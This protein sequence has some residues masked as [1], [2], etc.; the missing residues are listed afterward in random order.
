VEL[1]VDLVVVQ[2]QLPQPQLE[3]H[4]LGTPVAASQ[5]RSGGLAFVPVPVPRRGLSGGGGRRARGRF[6]LRR[7]RARRR[8]GGRRFRGGRRGRGARAVGRGGGGR[9]ARRRCRGRTGRRCRGGRWG[10][11]GVRHARPDVVRERPVAGRRLVGEQAAGP[12]GRADHQHHGAGGR[13]QCRAAP[14]AR[15]GGRGGGAVRRVR[16]GAAGRPVGRVR[17]LEQVQVGGARLGRGRGERS[18]E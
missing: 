15:P 16:D 6:R 2:E 12:A 18:G 17:S 14:P 7:G 11:G 5:H 9:G 10:G 4:H 3:F 1:A 13:E 8:V